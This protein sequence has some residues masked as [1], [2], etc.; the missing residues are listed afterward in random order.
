MARKYD[1]LEINEAVAKLLE[2]IALASEQDQ[3]EENDERVRLM[4]IHGAKGLEFGSVFV[5]GLEE[6]LLPHAK[7]IQSGGDELEEERRLC[8][9]AMT[10]AKEKLYL[11][12]AVER[13]I[14]GETQANMPSRFLFELPEK[15]RQGQEFGEEDGEH[16]IDGGE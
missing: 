5:A 15:I 10:R 2:E 9:V 1:E 3:L 14:F 13:T 6:G 4:T 7:A 11:S 12:W 16:I 8:Y